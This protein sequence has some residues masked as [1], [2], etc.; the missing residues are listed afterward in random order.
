[1]IRTVLTA[2]AAAGLVLAVPAAAQQIVPVTFAKGKSAATL[3]GSIKGDQD[4]SYTIDARAGQTLTV[5]LKAT[6]GSVEMNVYAPGNDTAIS[7]GST[8]PYKFTTVLPTTG[9]YKVQVYQMRASARRGETASY[10]L[11]IGVTGSAAKASTDAL[12]PGTKYNATADISCTTSVGGKTGACKAGVIRKGGGNATVELNT[13]DGG[14]RSI[15]F[16]G[17]KASGSDSATPIKATKAGD[18]TT[19]RIGTVEVYYIPDAL[20]FGG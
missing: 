7:L 5:T 19:V 18:I 15:Y 9:R 2:F 16:T 11:T 6:K 17:G 1:M 20:V 14:Q 13:P 3:T 12:V 10:T 8:D 4:R